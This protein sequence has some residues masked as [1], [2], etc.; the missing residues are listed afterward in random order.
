MRRFGII[1]HII[2][3]PFLGIYDIVTTI[4]AYERMYKEWT[5]LVKYMQ[6]KNLLIR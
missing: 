6:R 1:C 2:I 3:I 5:K 4:I